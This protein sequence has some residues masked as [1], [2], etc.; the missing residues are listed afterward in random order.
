MTEQLLDSCPIRPAGGIVGTIATVWRELWAPVG[1]RYHALHL[2]NPSLPY[3]SLGRAHR[4]LLSVLGNDTP[5]IATQYPAMAAILIDLV[6]R[7]RRHTL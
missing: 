4:L 2:W 3:H 6:Q 5:Y 7:A 1:L